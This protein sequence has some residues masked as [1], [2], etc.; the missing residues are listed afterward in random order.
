MNKFENVVKFVMNFVLNLAFLQFYSK[1]WPKMNV[2]KTAQN[3]MKPMK[4]L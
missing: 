4:M 1:K 3:V 2:M